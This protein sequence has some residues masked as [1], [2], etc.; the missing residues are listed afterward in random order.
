[1]QALSENPQKTADAGKR[2][3]CWKEIA[4]YLCKGERTVKRWESE[5]GLPVHRV[6]GGGRAS[7][8]ALTAESDEWLGSRSTQELE[9]APEEL[10]KP[11]PADR[12][13]AAEL[14]VGDSALAIALEPDAPVNQPSLRRS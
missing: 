5:R 9:A 12:S 8:Y 7:V 13:S 14:D 1:M 3:D 10:T 4:S 11:E 6:P 2:L